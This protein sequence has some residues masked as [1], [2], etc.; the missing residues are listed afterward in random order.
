MS[1][2]LGK[3]VRKL[4]RLVRSVLT[5]DL[6]DRRFWKSKS[7]LEGHS[8]HASEAMYRL[9][10][11]DLASWHIMSART[12]SGRFYYLVNWRVN[13]QVAVAAAEHVPYFGDG[14]GIKRHEFGETPSVRAKTI[15]ERVL[16]QPG[17]FALVHSIRA[18]LVSEKVRAS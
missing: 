11:G 10:G 13:M 18:A 7:N 14:P 5:N 6:R 17:A 9:M 15:M 8:L 16:K 2:P 1:S 12:E 4:A 3:D